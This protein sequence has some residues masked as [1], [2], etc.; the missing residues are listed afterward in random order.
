M[1]SLK[2]CWT[3]EILRN[4]FWRSAKEDFLKHII[5]L[6]RWRNSSF[7]MA[8]CSL[9]LIF[10]FISKNEF[11][12]WIWIFVKEI[13]YHHEGSE[14]F[15]EVIKQNSQIGN[16]RGFFRLHVPIKQAFWIDKKD[17]PHLKYKEIKYHNTIYCH[18]QKLCHQKNV[19]K[20]YISSVF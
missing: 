13:F 8:S 16:L 15:I 2:P 4:S 9:S 18:Q 19:V 12:I 14:L 1:I 6:W 7:S 17:L 5:T 11:E 3:D 10:Y 20:I